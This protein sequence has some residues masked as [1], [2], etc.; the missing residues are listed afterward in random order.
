MIILNLKMDGIYGFDNFGISFTYPKKVVNSIIDG[1]HLEGRE[2]FRYK[3]AVV[4]MGANATG[5]T[6]LGKAL[7]K[8][9]TYV[10]TGNPAVLYDMVSDEKGTFEIDFVNDGFT[11]HRLNAVIDVAAS[12][13]EIEYKSASIDKMDSYEKCVDKLC[14]HTAEATR[15]LNALKQLVGP[16]S[17]RFAYPEIETSLKFDGVNKAVFSKTLK[18]I[19]GTL[20]PTLMDVAISKDLNDT[21]IIRRKN[22]EIIIQEGKLL[23]REVLSSGTAEGIDVAIFLASM[24]AKDKTFYYC[25]EHFSYIQSDIEKRIF[26][27]MLDRISNNEQL[28]FTTHNTDMLDLNLPKHS[29]MFLRKRIED[30]DYKVTAISASEI[31]KRNTDSIRSAVENDVFGSLPDDSLLD[32]LEMGWEDE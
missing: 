22:A 20:D 13:V 4:L 26:G 11:M 15:T 1:E 10:N 6:S 7:L 3:K 9:I 18:A 23:N 21:F 24:M 5:K 30:G 2:R 28:I 12:N 29:F 8:I 31:L 32:E 27:L 25:D 14:N 16:V 19:I 17:Y